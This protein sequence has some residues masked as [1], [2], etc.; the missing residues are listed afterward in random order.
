[1]RTGIEKN[2]INQVYQGKTPKMIDDPK[3]RT[4]KNYAADRELYALS[5]DWTFKIYSELF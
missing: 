5:K 1:M 2:V 4:L 3:T